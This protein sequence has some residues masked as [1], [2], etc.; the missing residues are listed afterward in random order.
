MSAAEVEAYRAD[1]VWPLRV[2][3]VHTSLRELQAEASP[4]ASL[5]ALG[6]VD[7]PV[8]QILGGASL[9]V[10][11]EATEALDERLPNGRLV[12]IDGAKHAA[13]HTHAA[14]FVAAIRAFLEDA[15]LPD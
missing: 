8:L 12:V 15:D 9:P 14:A 11:R 13:H 7:Q 2:A 3:A 6:G 4:A 5:D 10:F 1:P